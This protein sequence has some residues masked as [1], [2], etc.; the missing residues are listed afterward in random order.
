MSHHYNEIQL[1]A[2]R[3]LANI[4]AGNASTALSGMLGRVV[5]LTVPNALVLPMSEAVEALGPPESEI[6]GI[7]LGVL[8]D[9]PSTVL[10]LLTPDAADTVC[11]L[12]GLEPDSE[13]A[14]SALG[15]IGNVV[16]TSYINALAGMAGIELEPTP[17]ATATDMLGALVQS[18]LA[19]RAGASDSTLLLDSELYVEGEGFS[20]S[21]LLVPDEGGA[22]LMLARL[23]VS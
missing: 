3:E 11:R 12:L 4:G 20:I 1:D 18:V 16:G 10:M 21:F 6:T 14:P 19:P 23:G 22:E 15:E 7:A 8:G 5:D 2:L 17:P 13:L 9:M